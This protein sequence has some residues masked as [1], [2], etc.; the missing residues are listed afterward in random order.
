MT[1]ETPFTT[2]A[3]PVFDREHYH[4]WAVKMKAYLDANDLWKDV[5]E[6]YEILPLPN[7]PTL[8]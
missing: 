5:E 6:D 8:A 2:V 4:I 1:S 3:P 7:N